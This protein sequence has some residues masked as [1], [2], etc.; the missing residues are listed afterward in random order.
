MTRDN[1]F[2]L[3]RVEETDTGRELRIVELDG[4]SKLTINRTAL[5][6]YD[7]W[8]SEFDRIVLEND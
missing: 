1:F 6:A 5:M 2:H 4:S 3:I 8:N 7:E